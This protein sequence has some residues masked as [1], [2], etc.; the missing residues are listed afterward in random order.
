M[1]RTISFS[2]P[3]EYDN[4]KV[5]HFLRGSARLSARLIG[6]LKQ[7]GDGILLNGEHIRTVD[8][9]KAGD[10]ITVNIP[11]DDFLPEPVNIPLDILY[12]DHDI[13]AVNKSPLMAMHPTHNHQGDTL[14][15][16]VAW[17]LSG[18]GNRS[19]FRAIGRLDKGTSGVVICTLNKYSASKLT[20]SVKKEYLA[21]AQGEFYGEGTIDAPIC[22]PNPMKTERACGG[23]GDRAVTHWQAIESGGGFSLLRLKLETG[24][25]HQIRVHFAFIGAPL[26]GDSM[27]G[28]A[29]PETGHQMLHCESA[30]FP[31]P[32][33]GE[34]LKITAP[35]PEEM[36]EYVRNMKRRGQAAD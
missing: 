35:M 29:F 26:L 2:V 6:S 16:A 10:V 8:M 21:V 5:A 19:A 1:P 34:I 14:A 9:I 23:E 31:H 20:G 18:K 25:T 3:N 13:I 27:Y 4:R 12:E 15:N 28:G 24:R 36:D 22:R 32:I 17:H 7:T 30:E 33:T 11:D